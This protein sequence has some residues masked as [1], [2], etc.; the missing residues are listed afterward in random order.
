MLTAVL[1]LLLL[2]ATATALLESEVG[3]YDAHVATLGGAAL[4]A[5]LTSDALLL[6]ATARAGVAAL[7]ARTGAL[8]WRKFAL[9]LAPPTPALRL[10]VARAR[11]LV[12]SPTAAELRDTA[13][14]AVL[15]RFAVSRHD[16]D[17]EP[18]AT[19]LS[20][21]DDV[22]FRWAHGQLVAVAVAAGASTEPLWSAP[23]PL[24]VGVRRGSAVVAALSNS[25]PAVV[26]VA[27]TLES[28]ALWFALFDAAS[29]AVV[30][31]SRSVAPP[32]GRALA[33]AAPVLVDGSSLLRALDRSGD[34]LFELDLAAAADAT[35]DIARRLQGTHAFRVVAPIGGASP[36]VVSAG[37]EADG[38]DVVAVSV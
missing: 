9:D 18:F 34:L 1:L 3:L 38:D 29:G 19:A 4:A 21:R 11:L 33:D 28:G 20:R 31:R 37:V 23:V 14:G 25:S 27:A 12:Q 5:A 17:N 6:V 22:L 24:P 10:T 2:S 32:D 7:D 30:M 26:A 15:W 13:S 16:D 36:V 8:R 35:L